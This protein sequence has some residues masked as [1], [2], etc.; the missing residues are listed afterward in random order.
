MNANHYEPRYQVGDLIRNGLGNLMRITEISRANT[1]DGFSSGSAI[2]EGFTC[3]R[4]RT[5]DTND[6]CVANTRDLHRLIDTSYLE[7]AH[8]G[9]GAAGPAQCEAGAA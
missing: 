5:L 2:R 7:W 3:Y 8:L 6:L 4:M 1:Q 9:P